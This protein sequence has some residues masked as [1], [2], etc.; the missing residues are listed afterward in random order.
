MATFF[1]L[2]EHVVSLASSYGL[3]ERIATVALHVVLW[4]V[5]MIVLHVSFLS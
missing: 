1:C 4:I 5:E 2:L 3:I